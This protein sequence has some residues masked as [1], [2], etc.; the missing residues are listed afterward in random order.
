MKRYYKTG[1]NAMDE[2][3]LLIS[4]IKDLD[5]MAYDRNITRCTGFLTMSEQSVYL[6]I[7][8]ELNS[9]DH[10]LAGGHEDAERAMIIWPAGYADKAYVTGSLISCILALPADARFADDLNHRD[11][12]GALMNLGIERH[13]LG[14]ILV[15]S[16]SAYIFCVSE[17]ADFIVENLTQVKHT[18]I[19]CKKVGL[20]ECDIVPVFDEIKV[21]V[22]SERIDA[23]VSAVYNIS[24]TVAAKL[25]TSEY[26]F[27]DG[28]VAKNSG[29]KIKEGARIS[30]RNHGKFIY[31]G[32]DG[33]SRKNRLYVRIKKYV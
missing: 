22:A 27:I 11:F 32:I 20:D 7:A 29:V 21:N 31:C 3:E 26:I 8:R 6:D 9:K 15:S 5:H 23:I 14:D 16:S 33:T 30:V 13:C 17:M 10:F 24:R 19:T 4:K 28:R 2:K 25:I 12:L 18:H 1:E